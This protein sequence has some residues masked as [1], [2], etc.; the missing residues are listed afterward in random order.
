LRAIKSP[1]TQ[2]RFVHSIGC[3]RLLGKLIT[4]SKRFRSEKTLANEKFRQK[5]LEQALF[6]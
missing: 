4:L 2:S 6:F 3:N 1:V 5:K